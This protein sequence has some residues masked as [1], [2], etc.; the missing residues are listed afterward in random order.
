LKLGPD[1]QPASEESPT[2]RYMPDDIFVSG[3]GEAGRVENLNIGATVS[4]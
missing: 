3:E 2:R 1:G 4:I